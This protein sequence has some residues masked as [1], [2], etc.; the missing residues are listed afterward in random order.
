MLPPVPVPCAA[1]RAT[2]SL[3]LFSKADST[4]SK[5]RHQQHSGFRETDVCVCVRATPAPAT[6]VFIIHTFSAVNRCVWQWSRLSVYSWEVTKD[7]S[8]SIPKTKASSGAENELRTHS[9]CM[10]SQLSP[11]ERQQWHI[12]AVVSALVCYNIRRMNENENLSFYEFQGAAATRHRDLKRNELMTNIQFAL[13]ARLL[14]SHVAISVWGQCPRWA[15]GTLDCS[16]HCRCV[17]EGM[18]ANS[19]VGPLRRLDKNYMDAGHSDSSI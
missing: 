9:T 6:N 18:D 12:K 13:S 16:L 10:S 7:E 5:R 17:C 19:V 14:C 2:S 4:K 3:L 8:S 11:L 1:P 15:A